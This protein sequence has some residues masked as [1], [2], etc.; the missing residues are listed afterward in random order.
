MFHEITL[1][2]LGAPVNIPPFCYQDSKAWFHANVTS[3][4]SKLTA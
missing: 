4:C 3:P 2:L 1:Q